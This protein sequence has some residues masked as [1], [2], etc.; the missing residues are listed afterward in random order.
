M[1]NPKRRFV[2]ASKKALAGMDGNF[3]SIPLHLRA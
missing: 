2:G 3:I 1:I